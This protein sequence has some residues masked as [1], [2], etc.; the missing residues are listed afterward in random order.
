M[1]I[2][3]LVEA[4]AN[5]GIYLAVKDG[6]L[7][8]KASEGALTPERRQLI[9]E[10]KSAFITFLQQETGGPRE[11]EPR[12]ERR[13]VDAAPLSPTQQRLWFID[14]LAQADANYTIPLIYRLEGALN[15]HALTRALQRVAERH[16]I[17]RTVIERRDGEPMAVVNSQMSV[18]TDIEDL[19][20]LDAAS[21]EAAIHARI[22]EAIGKPFDLSREAPIRAQ[23]M[24]LAPQQHVWLVTMHHIASDGWSVE[25]LLREV[26]ALYAAFLAGEADPL[27]PL[28]VQYADYSAWQRQWLQGDRLDRSRNYWLAQLKGAPVAHSLPLDRAR[29]AH[30]LNAGASW[31]QCLPPSLHQALLELGRHHGATLF[32]TMQAAFAVLVARWSGESDIVI[33]TPVANRPRDELAP[34]IGFFSN[35]LA[36]RTSVPG[37]ASF[38]EILQQA[39]TVALGAYEFQHLPF[40]L[41]VEE[42]NPP[43]S[44]GL[45]PLVQMMF[46]LQDID[47]DTSLSLPGITTQALIPDAVSTKFDLNL[48]LQATSQGLEACWD[49]SSDLFDT[50]TMAR[51]GASFETLLEGIVALP[52]QRIDQLPLLDAAAQRAMLALGNE[53]AA[54]H[55]ETDCLHTLFERQAERAPD[56]VAVTFETE[57]LSYAELNHLANQL[58]HQLRK[59]GV[60]PG[61]LVAIAVERGLAMLTGLLAILKTGG[62][63]VPLDPAYPEERLAYMLED[64]KPVALLTQQSLLDQLPALS[65]PTLLLDDDAAWAQESESNLDVTG[66]TPNHL[67]Y[68]I[69]TSGSTGQPKGV[70][71]EH[72]SVSR[73]LASTEAH[74]H[75]DASDVWTLFHSYAFDFSVWEIWGALAYGGHLVVVPLSCAR[76]PGDLYAL[77]CREKVTVLNQ[78]PSA[79]RALIGAQD[80]SPHHLRCIIFGGEALEL[81][82]LAP[83]VA[84]NDLQRTRL[85]NMYGITEITVH[86]TFKEIERADIEADSG[87]L[88]GRGLSDLHIYLLDAQCQPVPVGVTGE[89]YVGGPGVARGYLNRTELTHSRFLP[90][91]F[92]SDATA[93]MYKSGDLGKWSSDG[94]LQYLG[95]NDFQV[96]LRGFRI[97]LGE[98][99][100]KLAACA[101]VHQA[102]VIAREDQPSDKRLV[103]YVIAHE[104]HELAVATLRTELSSSLADYMVPSAFVLLQAFPLTPNGK[105]DRAALP[106]PDHA[107]VVARQY[108]APTGATEI[109]LASLWLDLLG[110]ARIGRDDNFFELGGHSLLLTRL[111]NQ[112][113]ALYPVEIALKQ[114]FTAQSIR[115]QACLIDAQSGRNHHA[116]PAPQARPADA[117]VVLSFAQ[118]RLWFIDQMGDAGAVYNIPCALRLTGSLQPES[119]RRAL[120][121]IV[122][123]HEVLRTP[124]ASIDGEVEPRRLDSFVLDVPMHDLRGL[125]RVARTAAIQTRMDAEAAQPFDLAVDLF[126]RAQLLQL[127]DDE[128]VLLL[129]LHHIASDGW[130]MVVLLRELAELYEATI[131][132]RESTLPPLTLQYAD[133]AH[134]QQQWLQGERLETQLTYWHTQLAALPVLHNLPL[135]HARPETQRYRGAMHR[136]PLDASLLAALKRLA[137]AHDATLFMTLQAA[138]AVLTA[139]WSGD[140]DVVLGTPIANR[141]HEQLSPLI[142]LFVNTLVLRHDFSANPRFTDALTAA[143]ETALDAFQHQDVPFEMLVDRLRPQRSMSHSPLFQIMFSLDTNDAAVIPFAGLEVADVASESH[144]AKF[145]LTLSMQE[146]A[147]GL[148][149]CWDYNRD[150]FRADSVARIAASFEALLQGIVEDPQQR[151]QQL[152]L[153][154]GDEQP[155]E[156]TAGPQLALSPVAG[157]HV[158]FEAN[159]AA[160]PGKLAVRHGERHISYAAL[161]HRANRVAHALRERGVG[162]DARVAIHAERSID[163]FVGVLAVLKAGGAY[164]PLDPAHP[165]ERLAR[166]L[167]DSGARVLLTQTGLH[168][169][170][171]SNEVPR[172]MLDDEASFESYATTNPVVPELH[173]QHMA[174]VIYTSGSTGAPKGVMVEH[175]ALLNMAEDSIRYFGDDQPIE[176][177]WWSSFGFDVSVFEMFFALTTGATTHIVPEELRTDARGYLQW[178]TAHRITQAAFPPFIVRALRECSDAQIAALSLRRLMTGIEPL[179]ENELHRLHRLLPQLAVVNSYGPT[180]TT[181]YSTYY[182]DIRDLRR[183]TPIG[184]PVANTRIHVWDGAMRPVPAGVVGEVYIAGTGVARGYLNQPELTAGRFLREAS[185]ERMYKTGDLARWLPDGQLEFRGRS[186]LQFKLNGVRIEPGEIEALMVGYPGVREAAVVVRADHG[187]DSK[188]LVA[189]LTSRDG[190]P[191]SADGIREYLAQRLPPYMVPTAYVTLDELP[192][193]VNGKLA[194]RT[195][196]APEL[197]A[198][199]ATAY[200]PPSTALEQRLTTIWQALLQHEQI[201]VTANFFDLGGHS[202]NA[203]RLMS[204]IR[205]ATGKALPISLL[206]K[207]PTIRA[208]AAHIDHHGALADD[209]LVTLRDGGA[210]PAL[211]VFHAAGGDVLC[212]QPLLQ[213]LPP[214]MP[215]HGFHRS[216]LSHQRVPKLLSIEQLADQYLPRMLEQQPVGPFYLAGWSSGGLLALEIAA[217][218]EK[219]GHPIAAVMLVDTMLATGNELPARLR[220]AGLATLAQLPP[221][222]VCDLLCEFDPTLAKITPTEGRLDVP[223]TDY[224]NYLVAANQLGIDFHRP[225]FQLSSRVHYFGCALNQ[226]VCSEEQRMAEIQ[227]LVEEPITR[228]SFAATHFS[229][230][231]EPDA[232]KLG[233]AIAL[234]IE[235]SGQAAA[236]PSVA[237][238]PEAIA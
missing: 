230:M 127:A 22:Q 181:V 163:N 21:Q 154:A 35:T 219:L 148:E 156:Q 161:N 59:L 168:D 216:E 66:L 106:A 192:L 147:N 201:S 109:A 232:A 164:V 184:R 64:S 226:I 144:H 140:T 77:L 91:P 14:Q 194:A 69:Y 137:R 129:T 83:W 134:W 92:Q 136:Q 101:G 212:Y 65:I 61:A 29:P 130:S 155:P 122:R 95:R 228:E 167:A 180:E 207:A 204:A 57:S 98:I 195:L 46:S 89:I 199:T 34:L 128:H 160:N 118:R 183:N 169:A 104:G 53:A 191:L 152:P 115:E 117:E 24:Q 223:A 198:Y 13:F 26:S 165:T 141:R 86:A 222:A 203:V 131:A 18:A 96:K 227:T 42:L 11:H 1:Q 56:A 142:G 82:T 237:A 36:L 158:L 25:N 27:A 218:L 135:D 189:Y 20:A 90:D 133:Y 8:C 4:L 108:D 45:A 153:L 162:P 93:R 202:L 149:A 138:F 236:S 157:A 85:I 112:I 41:L 19:K 71:V 159:A 74:F 125:D 206:F 68:V 9:A 151:I 205:E 73:L 105:L 55:F 12:L 172:L 44:L 102:Q 50:D 7:L 84:R 171:A 178:L 175:A 210:R 213:Y 110:L 63:Y 238:W 111:H 229:I 94:E 217:R 107:S 145:D 221:Q 119:L 146:S 208:L 113:G 58:A 196:P 30:V 39:K 179:Q 114:L 16:D 31:R 51:M 79:F 28:S 49:Y 43:R 48:N 54:P 150:L 231:E 60:G 72:G 174:Y 200:V 32:M 23:L 190:S 67:A 211:F 78:T 132:Q 47:E 186:D 123:R 33:G 120:E 121:T 87:S 17:L 209:V 234:V 176:A 100:A 188:Q 5:A 182:T 214:D 224:F 187:P 97:E 38:V 143:R 177:A 170:L 126:L 75:F 139:R 99:E 2:D 124:L 40:D 220:D 166:M 62:A 225:D 6:K 193:T 37:D 233:R 173:Q 103:A 185:G 215:V 52:T 88:I 116:L 80:S 76:S 197:S 15:V 3:Q 10:Q 70:M 235:R 81:H